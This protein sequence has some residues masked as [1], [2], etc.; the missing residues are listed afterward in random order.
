MLT[1][2]LRQ[3]GVGAINEA[4]NAEFARLQARV[5]RPD[6][7][8]SEAAEF[9]SGD[10]LELLRSFRGDLQGMPEIPF[11][12]VI[13][14]WDQAAQRVA[15][16]AGASG[17]LQMPVTLRDVLR[18]VSAAVCDSTDVTT[19]GS[20]AGPARRGPVAPPAT[21]ANRQAVDPRGNAPVRQPTPAAAARG[22]VD[23]DGEDLPPRVREAQSQFE[24][25]L[26]RGPH[27]PPK[28][29]EREQLLNRH[30]Q[31][32]NEAMAIV[33]EMQPLID[34][35]R[36]ASGQAA[37]A[38]AGRLG[39]LFGR[40]M[41]LAVLIRGYAESFPENEFFRR[42]CD[43]IRTALQSFSLGVV[44]TGLDRTV[45]GATAIIEGLKPYTLGKTAST[46][47]KMM[48]FEGII[49]MFGGYDTLPLDVLER[50]KLGWECVLSLSNLDNAFA[51]PLADNL[52]ATRN[53]ASQKM[54]RA[55]DVLSERPMAGT[56]QATLSRLRQ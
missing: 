42:S 45:S 49:D 3:I 52:S 37:T 53:V 50:V 20:S 18:V 47:Y 48:E 13:E 29:A 15:R 9:G 31:V 44:V 6:I 10:H 12:Y 4:D 43:E 39:E 41:N 33:A 11:I 1:A 34:R 23:D 32:V 26:G 30:T 35:T 28:A 19:G 8:L 24:G 51:D 25:G 5:M 54:H 2:V 36:S 16:A 7:I 40:L 27:P 56:Q 21:P 14:N 55:E 46:Y 22:T 17:F 38:S